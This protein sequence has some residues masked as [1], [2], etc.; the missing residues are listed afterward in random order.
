MR[1]S[2]S[3]NKLGQL[4]HLPPHPPVGSPP[5]SSKP[6]LLPHESLRE[7]GLAARGG[8]NLPFRW[9]EEAVARKTQVCSRAR[10]NGEAD[11]SGARKRR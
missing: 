4:D 10:F 7:L 2:D 8:S 1:I 11:W 9:L 6:C 3:E 5:P